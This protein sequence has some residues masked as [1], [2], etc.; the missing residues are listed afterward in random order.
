MRLLLRVLRYGK[1]PPMKTLEHRFDSLGGSIGRAVDNDFYLPDE[2]K[3]VSRHHCKI[4]YIAHERR[5]R[6]TDL[7]SNASKV[8]GQS[9]GNGKSAYLANGSALMIGDYELQVMVEEGIAVAPVPTP[10]I[11][12][13]ALDFGFQATPSQHLQPN[14]NDLLG[15]PPSSSDSLGH[16]SRL[17]DPLAGASILNIGNNI[18]SLGGNFLG[19][20][21]DPLGDMVPPLPGAYQGAE[22]D[23]L[24]AQHM[25]YMA[26]KLAPKHIPDILPMPASALPSAGLTTQIPDDIDWLAPMPIAAPAPPI[27]VPVVPSSEPIVSNVPIVPIAPD[28]SASIS[29]PPLPDNFDPLGT[30]MG[31]GLPVVM[32]AVMPAVPPAPAPTLAPVMPV[33]VSA[34]MSAPA[35]VVVPVAA[36]AAVIPVTPVPPVP[37]Q[38]QPDVMEAL[39]RGLGI[40]DLKFKGSDA[41]LAE[42]VGKMLHCAVGGTMGV[43]MARSMTKRE[44]RVEATVL[45]QKNN[46][47]MKF[48]PNPEQAIAQMLTNAW[49][50]YLPGERAMNDAFDDLKAHELATIAGMRAALA[51]VLE[52]FDPAAIEARLDVPTVM[53]KMLAANRKAK[54]W[55]HLLALY[56]QMSSEA[57]D[58]F[59]R[60]FGE[61]FAIAYEEQTTRL[62]MSRKL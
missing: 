56:R 41:E 27:V 31:A 33:A 11:P 19:G 40:P 43:L 34:P 39:L 57:D 47:P 32:S 42:L 54:M 61:K 18:G 8:A 2:S 15:L 3:F 52:R 29:H 22:H 13:N 4:E 7:G 10:Q 6:L 44:I 17:Q 53:D 46:N 16:S 25:P 48:F 30:I 1:Q 26:P 38:A 62:R 35:P 23:H 21:F 24:A 58:D 37:Q 49:A 9:V 50:G 36:P 55:D 20:A 5:F 12:A 45:T 14:N 59:Q 51:G 60:L 28:A